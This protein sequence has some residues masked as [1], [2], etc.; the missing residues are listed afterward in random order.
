MTGTARAMIN[1]LIIEKAGGDRV[2]AN[3]IRIKLILKGINV[4]KIT[5]ETEDS[6]AMLERIREVAEEF[7][8]AL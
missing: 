3:S 5:A 4:D 2:L 8:V 6:D 1:K 7:C